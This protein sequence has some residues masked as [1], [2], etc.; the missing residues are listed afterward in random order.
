MFGLGVV[1][2]SPSVEV[3]LE[4]CGVTLWAGRKGEAEDKD[5]RGSGAQIPRDCPCNQ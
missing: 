3:L 5:G 4:L 1:K 2:G